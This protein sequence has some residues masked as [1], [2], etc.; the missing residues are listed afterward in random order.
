M[1]K[2]DWK[3]LSYLWRMEGAILCLGEMA[4]LGELW[5]LKPVQLEQV[6]FYNLVIKSQGANYFLLIRFPLIFLSLCLVTSASNTLTYISTL[7]MKILFPCLWSMRKNSPNFN[8]SGE[9]HLSLQWYQLWIVHASMLSHFSHVQLFVTPWIVAH[10]APLSTGFSRQEY[11]N[12]LPFPSPGDLPNAGIEPTPS[13]APALQA[14]SLPL[15]HQ[16]S[17]F[18]LFGFLSHIKTMGPWGRKESDLTQRLNCRTMGIT[19]KLPP[20]NSPITI[21]LRAITSRSATLGTIGCSVVRHL[22][23][24]RARRHFLCP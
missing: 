12:G 24:G 22:I 18:G 5:S 21:F 14:G 2:T 4:G 10:E 17:P 15:N 13:E 20:S 3:C 7:Q 19:S 9:V 6:T 23:W 11:W 16:I 1:L 8:F